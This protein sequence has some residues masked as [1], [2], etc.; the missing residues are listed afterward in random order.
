[1][2]AAIAADPDARRAMQKMEGDKTEREAR[3]TIPKEARPGA[4]PSVRLRELEYMKA[5]DHVRF[6]VEGR[7]EYEALQ[8][9]LAEAGPQPVRALNTEDSLASL[10]ATDGGSALA[11]EWAAEAP[12][13]VATV[14]QSVGEMLRDMGDQ[15]A[16]GAFMYGVSTLPGAVQTAL[17][18]ELSSPS[19]SNITPAS[20]EAVAEYKAYGISD[21]MQ[22]AKVEARAKRALQS[23]V[24]G[25]LLRWWRGLPANQQAAV[26]KQLARG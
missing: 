4:D 7:A 2:R 18:K 15:Q 26:V 24:D 1:M 10:R 12:A 21:P 23:D 20:A 3:A 17:A 11:S 9:K 22:V 14:Q 6:V 13:K 8:A 19:P 5:H 16:Q 25:S